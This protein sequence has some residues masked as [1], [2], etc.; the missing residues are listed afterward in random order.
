M[1]VPVVEIFPVVE[2]WSP[3]LTGDIVEVPESLLQ[4]PTSELPVD[5]ILPEQVK[6][7]VASE[8][9]HPVEPE[10]PASSTLPLVAEFREI[11]LEPLDGP[12]ITGSEPAKVKAVEVKVFVLI[13]EVKVAAPAIDN[14]PVP[15]VEI[16]PVVVMESPA[17]EGERDVPALVQ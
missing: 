7:P 10:P 16:P 2:I 4:N 12:E 8:I 17:V 3:L 9:V 5:E 13:V 15:V 6:L 11:V 14:V 1:P